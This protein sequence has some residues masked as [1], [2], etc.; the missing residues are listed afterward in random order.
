MRVVTL[1]G[2]RPQFIKAAPV[3]RALRQQHE[4]VLI[5]SGQHYD[6]DMSDVFF[7]E[8]GIPRPDHNL[9]VG[10]GG[11]GH[12]TG[13]MMGPLEDLLQ[14]SEPDMVI[15]YGDTNTTL[16]GAITAAKLGLP[17]AH[18]E[19][20]LRSF[21]RTMPEEVNRV[22]ADHV[23]DLLLAPTKA[24]IENLTAEGITEGVELVGDVM[25]DTA[26]H[27]AETQDAGPVLD[28]LGLTPGEYFFATVHRA[29]NAD[30]PERLAAIVCALGRL[31]LPVVWSVHP[32]T[33]ASLASF[34]L[35]SV[36][37]ESE[38]VRAIPPV[39]YKEAVALI[40]NAAALLTD[41][42][43][44]QKEAYFFGV[45]C[46]TLREETE[47]VETVEL[48]WNTLVG[49]D[50]EAIVAAATDLSRPDERPSVYGDGHAAEAV[51]AA[52]EAHSEGSR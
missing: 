24:A 27:F 20:G 2:A 26:R 13:A 33:R 18:I 51:V 5:H 36:V 46:V 16:A 21:N 42:G 28:G 44:M 3:S 7:E 14:E 48:G 19:A 25:L 37:E 41:S 32:R 38:N 39:S 9:G 49:S 22:V 52:I 12:M 30:D 40:R 6:Y 43:G 11:H 4:E 34:G 35:A 1:V 29:G 17:V 45:P 47:W 31:P 15:V 10:S 50:E 8:L 23:C